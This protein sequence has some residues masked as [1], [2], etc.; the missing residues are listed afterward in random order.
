MSK[1]DE[2]L[3][4]HV[5]PLGSWLYCPIKAFAHKTFPLEQDQPEIILALTSLQQSLQQAEDQ[6]K[7]FLDMDA[8]H[9]LSRKG[10]DMG[11]LVTHKKSTGFTPGFQVP[12]GEKK[13]VPQMQEDGL[14]MA[15]T[16]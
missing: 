14:L 16:S 10:S 1:L 13:S 6:Q 5:Q 3:S 2:T 7:C 12:K 11:Q 8:S 4:T 9:W 15:K